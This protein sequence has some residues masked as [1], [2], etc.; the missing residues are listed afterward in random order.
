M[1][2]SSSIS[3]WEHNTLTKATLNK[4]GFRRQNEVG[5][6][7]NKIKLGSIPLTYR[8]NIVEYL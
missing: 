7:S 6:A 2:H 3:S 4:T 1:G 5:L 8:L